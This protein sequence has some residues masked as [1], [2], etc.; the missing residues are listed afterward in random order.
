[1]C[2]RSQCKKRVPCIKTNVSPSRLFRISHS[3]AK[4]PPDT[5]SL[6]EVSIDGGVPA[7]VGR[8]ELLCQVDP[9]TAAPPRISI[10]PV[11]LHSGHSAMRQ[12]RS[13][14]PCDAPAHGADSVSIAGRGGSRRPVEDPG[15][16]SLTSTR[17]C[18]TLRDILVAIL[19]GHPVCRLA[20]SISARLGAHLGWQLRGVGSN[21][22]LSRSAMSR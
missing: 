15:P 3:R 21:I 1:M 19:G 22:R 12:E 20:V 2:C 6:V 11:P 10:S 9:G 7:A 4:R 8:A 17:W 13:G 5:E 18:W 16:A 14:R